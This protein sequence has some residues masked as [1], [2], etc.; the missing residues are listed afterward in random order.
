MILAESVITLGGSA[1]CDGRE[2]VMRIRLGSSPRASG[3]DGSVSPG[4]RFPG[5][6]L[7]VDRAD[8]LVYRPGFAP[9]LLRLLL[10][11][12]MIAT[13]LLFLYGY[14]REVRAAEERL[15]RIQSSPVS[16]QEAFDNALAAGLDAATAA[17]IQSEHEARLAAP[18]PVRF[19]MS[20]RAQ[21]TVRWG[22][23]AFIAVM[24]L[25]PLSVI[26][27]RVELGASPRGELVVKSWFIVPRTVRIP[28]RDIGG[29][30]YGVEETIHRT[31]RGQITD[32]YWIWHVRLKAQTP[33]NA[34]L[35]AFS[36]WK[37]PER[38]GAQ[39]RP[40]RQVAHLIHWLLAHAPVSVS[41]PYLVEKSSK[42][43][44]LRAEPRASVRKGI[45]QGGLRQDRLGGMAGGI[46]SPVI[47]RT[48]SERFV[49]EDEHGVRKSFDSRDAIPPDIRDKIDEAMLRAPHGSV[50][51]RIVIRDADGREQ[52]Y[53][54]PENVPDEI[55]RRI[56]EL[57]RQGK[58][59][60]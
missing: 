55:R 24:V 40:P 59:Q 6:S 37:Q 46:E 29:I 15:L 54:S 45:E 47:H 5:W 21:R 2:V 52:H 13:A 53:D 16:A 19:G 51:E 34:C 58:R 9:F 17:R 43:G 1:V 42:R 32:H 8:R 41:G 22:G 30:Q 31:T 12:V 25:F 23:A 33:E 36:P 7:A 57:R 26:W 10:A 48:V 50:S 60:T 28:W 49:Y 27:N 35:A 14:D 56:E 38:P 39:S 4:F 11:I 44:R 3:G 18:R 20:A